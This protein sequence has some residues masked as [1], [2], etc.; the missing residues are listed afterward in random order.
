MPVVGRLPPAGDEAARDGGATTLLNDD[1]NDAGALIIA[2]ANYARLRLQRAARQLSKS[3]V[4]V[5][6][7]IDVP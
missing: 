2:I 4:P 7:L 5:I 6:M 3:T 1:G